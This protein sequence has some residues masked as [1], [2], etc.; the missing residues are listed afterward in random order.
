VNVLELIQ[1]S[2]EFLTRKD[3]ESARLQAELLLA[4]VLRVPRM[5]LYLNFEKT[6]DP[7]Q[8]AQYRELV[9]RRGRREP[10]QHIIGSVSFCG[11]EIQVNRH[12][13]VPRPETELLA[14]Q[15]WEFLGR[16]ASAGPADRQPSAL[17]FGTGSGCIAVALAVKCPQARILGMDSSPEAL[18]VAGQN[19]KNLG[20]NSH[21]QFVQADGLSQLKTA[22]PFH[23][24]I[25]NPP[26]IPS[27]EIEHLQPEVRD[28]EP[29]SALDGGVDGLD[30]YRLIAAE[31]RPLL[32]D[33]GKVMLEFG[34]GQADALRQIFEQQNW[35][36]EPA[37]EDYTRRPRF[38]I[39]ASHG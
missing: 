9:Q 37:L 4:H 12:V 19:A 26:Y 7:G 17:D 38:L 32:A 28:F 18:A 25:G 10:L 14:Q 35:I 21:V 5:Q 39:A 27:A 24:L 2:T 13:L 20:V 15:G 33:Q 1:R 11:L 8:Q 31:A 16:L 6:I 30:Y 34:D 23:L 29:R 3:V 36:V 22:G